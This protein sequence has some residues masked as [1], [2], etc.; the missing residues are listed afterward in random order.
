MIRAGDT[1]HN[2]V[3]LEEMA[4][5][6]TH[7]ETNGVRT[8][9]R[10]TL[11]PRAPG[12]F[13]HFHTTFTEQFLVLEGQLSMIAGDPKQVVVL[14]PGQSQ[15][16]PLRASHRFWNATDL[17]VTFEVEIRPSRRFEETIE[18]LFEL[19]NRGRTKP[20]GS[21]QHPFDLAFL[22][23]MSESYLPGPPVWAQRAL[24]AFIAGVARLLGYRL[25]PTPRR[26]SS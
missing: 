6:E 21:P 23:Q 4:F 10:I 24:F 7:R 1:L 9:V 2:P 25:L 11:P 18:T 26:T 8:L 22:A 3:T 14:R 15:F 16:V 5:L 20:D 19:A 12:V 17:P 13:L